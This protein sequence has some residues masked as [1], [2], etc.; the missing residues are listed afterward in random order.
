[1]VSI[2]RGYGI[3]DAISMLHKYKRPNSVEIKKV[4]IVETDLMNMM[5]VPEE[6]VELCSTT[7]VQE[8]G[9]DGFENNFRNILAQ[10]FT[11]RSAGLT[12]VYLCSQDMK[13]LYVTSVEKINKQYH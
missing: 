1:M 7:M 3:S 5:I 6:L 9:D 13:N 12:P 11:F 4:R 10:G 2:I 8:Y